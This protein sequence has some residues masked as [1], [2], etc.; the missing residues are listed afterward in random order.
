MSS[1]DVQRNRGGRKI[2]R[3]KRK[4]RVMICLWICQEQGSAAYE[5]VFCGIKT[6]KKLE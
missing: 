5:C 3:L 2:G 6:E 1:D 4:T